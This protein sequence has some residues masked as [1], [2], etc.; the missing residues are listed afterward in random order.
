MP[1]RV[2]VEP[3]SRIAYLDSIRGIA[4]LLVV[5]YHCWIAADARERLG[6]TGTPHS[7]TSLV[8]QVVAR[9]FEA[10][11]AS[12]MLFFV[13][14]GYVLA[15]SL[16]KHRVS[17]GGYA[18]KRILRIYPAFFVVIAA[19]Y[20]LHR[21]FGVPPHAPSILLD[22]LTD[23]DL[24]AP[25]LFKALT[26]WGTER[27]VDL[28]LV[29]WS[30]VHEMRISLLFP[31]ILWSVRAGGRSSLAFFAAFSLICTLTL[32]FTGGDFAYG[33]VE[34]SVAQSWLATGYFIVFF[35]GGA[36]LSEAR[37]YVSP[38]IAPIRLPLKRGAALAMVAIFL[39]GDHGA[40]APGTPLLDYAHGL[41]AIGII[42]LTM[43]TPEIRRILN[44]PT[45]VWLGR[46][47]YSLYLV[48]LPILYVVTA[49]GVPPPWI[50]TAIVA[51]ASLGAAEIGARW[52][53]L[54]AMQ[55]GRRLAARMASQP[56]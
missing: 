28:D 33:F 55:L 26:M 51:A 41:A 20:V 5:A 36:Y 21:A 48:H 34:T 56:A 35:A 19:S 10:G 22:R 40:R 12:V 47:S 16:A 44:H 3:A 15:R 29:T 49:L 45:L 11:R 18:I 53:E 37:D 25:E 23:P 31:L 32:R 6:L 30:L 54:P 46:V 52:V 50:T 14:S 4:A 17:Y 2:A 39:I 27:S 1:K 43:G 13:L 24:S 9:L 38:R 8:L 42:A 7:V